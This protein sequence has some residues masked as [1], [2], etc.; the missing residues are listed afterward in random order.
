MKFN[1][2]ERRSMFVFGI[3]FP[4]CGIT[5][6]L[7]RK[8]RK[9]LFCAVGKGQTVHLSLTKMELFGI[10]MTCIKYRIRGKDVGESKRKRT[11]ENKNYK[12]LG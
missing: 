10:I 5:L 7:C 1:R 6:C 12:R 2:T 4:R 8:D 11:A 3:C 9:N